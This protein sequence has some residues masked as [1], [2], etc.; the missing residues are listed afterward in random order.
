M[1]QDF[2]PTL[3]QVDGT[4]P[5]GVRS[6]Q[7]TQHVEAQQ[8]KPSYQW[9]SACFVID[10]RMTLF[11]VQSIISLLVLGVCVYDLVT[12]GSC[13]SQAFYGNILM[14]LVGIWLPSPMGSGKK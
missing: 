9:R 10:A 1:Q 11:V 8:K 2:D 7:I 3:S 4:P 6:M 12:D 5:V 14:T 13:E